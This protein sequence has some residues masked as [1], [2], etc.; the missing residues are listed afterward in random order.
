MIVALAQTKGGVGKTM[1]SVN[2]AVE[3]SRVGHDVLLI[4]ADTQG[5]AADFAAVRTET[6]KDPGFTTVQ[7][8]G[9]AV[10]T[11]CLRLGPKYADIIIDCGGRDSGG[12]RAALTVCDVAVI[13]FQPRTADIWTLDR[14]A[15]LI[16]EA[17]SINPRLRA[18]SVVN[19]ADSAGS[20][21]D[22]AASV[23]GANGEIAYSQIMIG[24]RKAF[25]NAFIS[26]LGV[27]ELK[28]PDAKACAEMAALMSAAFEISSDIETRE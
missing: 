2:V 25:E 23:L 11:E 7:L 9:A 28:R 16:A 5:T 12:L 15:E 13:P 1:L 24:R 20:S 19:C 14:M 22:D 4:D 17:R 8:S 6:L 26:G 10:R 3:R 21:N 18:L 27:V